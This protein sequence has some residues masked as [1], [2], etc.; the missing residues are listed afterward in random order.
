V[1]SAQGSGCSPMAHALTQIPYVLIAAAL[2]TGVF[3]L[4]GFL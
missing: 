3:L 1:L 2:A 4:I